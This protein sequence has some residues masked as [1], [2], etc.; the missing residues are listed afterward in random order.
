MKRMWWLILLGFVLSAGCTTVRSHEVY[1][2]KE[3]I[4]LMT[5][6]YTSHSWSS[7]N[8]I[9]STMERKANEFCPGYQKVCDFY[10]LKQGAWKARFWAFECPPK[11][12]MSQKEE[13]K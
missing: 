7:E 3:N 2:I 12:A 8:D 6:V 10:G 13:N 5:F 4:Y 9:T 11:K 1:P